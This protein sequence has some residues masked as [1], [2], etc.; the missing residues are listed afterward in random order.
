MGGT[1]LL[2]WVLMKGLDNE[3]P[4]L[5]KY[6]DE[7]AAKK[8]IYSE[9]DMLVAVIKGGGHSDLAKVREETNKRRA[10]LAEK[11][12]QTTYG[13]PPTDTSSEK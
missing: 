3:N 12:Y 4:A 5:Q 1:T 10:E 7:K 6:K 2:G 11:Y 9:N 8:G 13:T